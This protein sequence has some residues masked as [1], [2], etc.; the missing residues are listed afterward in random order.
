MSAVA[1]I[2]DLWP[3]AF[4]EAVSP[5]PASILRQQG[6]YLSEKT[7][8]YVYGEVDS[9]TEGVGRFVHTF[10]IRAPR[11]DVD[12]MAVVARHSL[13]MYP[14]ELTLLELNGSEANKATAKNADEFFDLLRDMLSAPHWVEFIGSLVSQVRELD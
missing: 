9:K 8:N 5:S 7:S 11:I 2:P 10:A 12:Q 14:A 4:E 1:S 6:Y 13:K 3:K